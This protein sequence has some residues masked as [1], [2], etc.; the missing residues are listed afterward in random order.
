MAWVS[1]NFQLLNSDKTQVILFEPKNLRDMIYN[2]IAT[3][4]VFTM[5]KLGV[6][7]DRD[8]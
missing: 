6:I 4:D 3:L 1:C 8:L 7:F 2:Q 5:R